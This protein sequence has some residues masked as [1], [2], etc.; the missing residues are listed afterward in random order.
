MQ[1]TSTDCIE[2]FYGAVE[3]GLGNDGRRVVF[4]SVTAA[5]IP[6]GMRV[7]NTLKPAPT[8]A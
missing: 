8:A 5:A 4:A 1:A 2:P 7:L 3:T 6:P